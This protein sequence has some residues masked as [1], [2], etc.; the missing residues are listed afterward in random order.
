MRWGYDP[1]SSRYR[2]LDSGRFLSTKAV[3]KIR[4]DIVDKATSE[5]RTLA[6]KVVNGTM[7]VG[8][9]GA[10]MRKLIKT[11]HSAQY[12][13]GKGGVNALTRRDFGAMGRTLKAEYKFLDGFLRDL[14][15]PDLDAAKV[16]RRAELYMESSIKSYERARAAALKVK[17]PAVTP[18]AHS[19][20][21]CQLS[22]QTEDGKPVVYWVTAEDERV[23]PICTGLASQYN[24]LTLE[25]A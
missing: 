22:Y 14:E 12:S 17:P 18:P 1:K 8:D 2:N 15:A 10:E 11:V 16:A 23:C 20:C 24:P 7:T 3:V 25:A 5:A 21:R 4:D 13:L 9:F 6:G 19:R